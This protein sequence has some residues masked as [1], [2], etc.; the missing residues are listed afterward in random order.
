MQVIPSKSSVVVKGQL[1]RNDNDNVYAA[2]AQVTLVNNAITFLFS[3]CRYSIGGTIMERIANPGQITS[4]L[5]YLYYNDDYSSTSGLK[6]CWS[7]DKT[8]NAD[9]NEFMAS[10]AAPVAGY[11]PVRNPNYN[12]GFADRQA[13]LMSATPRG[14]FS[15]VIPLEHLFGFAEYDKIIY[16]VKHTLT[17]TRNGS[18]NYAI[19][20]AGGVPDGKIKLMNITWRVP[21]VRTEVGELMKLRQIIVDKRTIPVS[22]SARTGESISVTPGVVNFD[23]RIAVSSGVEK[24]RWIIVG[25][26]ANKHMSQE[27][28]PAVFDHVN[29]SNAYVT[30]N[31]E[32]YPSNDFVTNFQIMTIRYC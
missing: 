23:W 8:D 29:L 24:P 16:G 13:L 9:T 22:F 30:L 27:Q 28:N 25:F 26:Q 19:H 32:R 18:D 7:K 20:R 6:W 1:V 2:N 15:F 10:Q 5:G 12:K 3:E 4:M 21:V 31:G 14:S 17:L 11:I